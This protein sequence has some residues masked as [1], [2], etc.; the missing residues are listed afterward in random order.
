MDPKSSCVCLDKTKAEIILKYTENKVMVKKAAD[1]G[2]T[3]PEARDATKGQQPPSPGVKAAS[4]QLGASTA[5]KPGFR[6]RPPGRR[7][8]R[9][10]FRPPCV[11]TA[12]TG[13]RKLT[14]LTNTGP[15]QEVGLLKS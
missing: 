15:C 6:C 3:K 1:I 7:G 13:N 12:H 2:G 5:A 4:P 11:V 9:E 8:T 10:L 14:H